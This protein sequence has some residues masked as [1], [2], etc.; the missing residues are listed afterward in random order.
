MKLPDVETIINYWNTQ[1]CNIK[2]SDLEIGTLAYFDSVKAKRYKV[3]PHI[4]N[5]ADFS[6]SK[7][8]RILEIGC[9]IGTD[10]VEFA[11]NGADYVG[12]DL[13]SESIELSEKRFKVYN[14]PGKFYQLDAA[15]DLSFLGKFDLVYSFGVIHHYP[16]VEKIIDNVKNIL[17]PDGIFR[18]MVYSENSWKYAMIKKKLDQFEAQANCPY[19]KVYNKIEIERLLENKFFISYIKQDHCFMYKIPEYKKGIFELEPWFE[20]MPDEMKQAVKEYLGWHLL[21]E[22]INR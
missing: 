18:F 17:H 1:P 19:A 15:E 3:E 14:L 7:N 4:L 21:V 11:K 12:I 2:H 10:A 16:N 13:S 8:K 6:N 20:A 5:F 9:G 22:A